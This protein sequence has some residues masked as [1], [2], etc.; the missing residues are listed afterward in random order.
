MRHPIVLFA[1]ALLGVGLAGP[2]PASAQAQGPSSDPKLRVFA[3][4]TLDVAAIHDEID[5]LLALPENK[6]VERQAEI[7]AEAGARIAR[8]IE[9]RGLTR[10]EY[11][12]LEYLVTTD[13]EWRSAFGRRLEQARAARKEP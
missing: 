12:R 5:V 11:E 9:A 6:T 2:M 7:R 1:L 4:A 10:A 13:P 3:A 8:A